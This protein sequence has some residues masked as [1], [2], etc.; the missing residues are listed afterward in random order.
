M[1][2]VN[3]R[4]EQPPMPVI[5]FQKWDEG[6]QQIYGKDI[7]LQSLELIQELKDEPTDEELAEVTN[8]LYQVIAEREDYHQELED[9]R[10]TFKEIQDILGCYT[11]DLSDEKLRQL[12]VT[13]RRG[14]VT[15]DVLPKI[16]EKEARAFIE[17]GEK[18]RL[19]ELLVPVPI[20]WVSKY[21]S[22][23]FVPDR[24]LGV[25]FAYLPYSSELGLLAPKDKS[26]PGL[27][28]FW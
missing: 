22:Q 7:L 14:V 17:K 1:G 9:G 27:Y 16:F 28:E 13:R 10:R 24:D 12:F 25:Y 11:I 15:L 21:F 18:W 4:G 3:R 20:Q 6:S 5:I 19:V 23:W 8:R 26:S 2:R